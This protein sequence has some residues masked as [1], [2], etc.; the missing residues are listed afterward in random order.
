M[1]Y[2]KSLIISDNQIISDDEL[3]PPHKNN[4]LVLD[5]MLFAGSEHPKIAQAFTQYTHHRNLSVLYLVQN[6]FH[7]GEPGEAAPSV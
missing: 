4:L 7:Q 2:L 3:L 5:D 6:V 1:C